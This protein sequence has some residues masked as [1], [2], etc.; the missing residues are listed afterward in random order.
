MQDKM[1]L[2][3]ITVADTFNIKDCTY[4][5]AIQVEKGITSKYYTLILIWQ[6]D[7]Q[8]LNNC[9]YCGNNV[10]Q[11]MI[12]IVVCLGAGQPLQTFANG[13]VAIVFQVVTDPKFKIRYS[14]CLYRTLQWSQNRQERL[15]RGVA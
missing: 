2:K 14:T 6:K 15:F 11:N 1:S 7:Y 3:E 8:A 5:G 10:L 9:F 12:D 4:H 13:S